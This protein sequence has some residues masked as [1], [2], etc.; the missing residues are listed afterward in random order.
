[1]SKE[2]LA[3]TQEVT[4]ETNCFALTI[5]KDYNLSIAKNILCK[6]T[7]MSWKIALNLFLLNILAILF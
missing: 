5:R 7:R 4:N 3:L 2:N 1:M 6:T